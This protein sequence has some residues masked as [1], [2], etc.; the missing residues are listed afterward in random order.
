MSSFKNPHIIRASPD[1]AAMMSCLHLVGKSAHVP[2][3]LSIGS[4]SEWNTRANALIGLLLERGKWQYKNNNNN[5]KKKKK[6]KKNAKILIP[7]SVS[8]ETPKSS[9]P[10]LTKSINT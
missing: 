9:D 10:L 3:H 2:G 8:A 7:L 4:H 1:D 6:K 5:K